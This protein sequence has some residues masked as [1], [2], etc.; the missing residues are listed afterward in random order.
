MPPEYIHENLLA[1]TIGGSPATGS[2]TPSSEDA[3]Y[4]VENLFDGLYA[5]PFRSESPSTLNIVIDLGA[6]QSFNAVGIMG[7][8]GV[9]LAGTVKAGNS[10]SPSTVVGTFTFREQDMWVDVGTQAAQYIT[11]ELTDANTANIQIGELVIGQR[12]ALPRSLFWTNGQS[13]YRPHQMEEG[14]TLQTNGGVTWDYELFEQYQLEGLFRFPQSEY[15][16]FR[17]F[18]SRTKRTNPFVWIPNIPS[19][20]EEVYFVKRTRGMIVSHSQPGADSGSVRHWYDL[21]ITLIGE[22]LGLIA[23]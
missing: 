6:P 7:H 10:P 23:P 2:I 1:V 22:S 19:Q 9:A 21:P 17:L 11:I 14:V 12:V 4:P 13:S 8:N 18:H 5:K 15:A 3:A 16:Q 20:T